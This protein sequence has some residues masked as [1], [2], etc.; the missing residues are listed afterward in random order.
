MSIIDAIFRYNSNEILINLEDISTNENYE[1]LKENLFCS[2]ENCN[3]SL[4]YIP[5]GKYSE[6]LK[7]RVG[8]IHIE[9]CR[10]F[11]I[12][13]LNGRSR[14]TTGTSSSI[15]RDDHVANILRGLYDAYNE[16]D[17]ERESRL[18]QQR[19][20]ARRRRNTRVDDSSTRNEYD[21]V[22]S[23]RPTTSSSGEVLLEGERNP[24]VRRRYSLLDLSN[25]DIGQTEGVIGEL[26]EVENDGRRSLLL[27]SDKNRTIRVCLYL[28]EVFF[29]NSPENLEDNLLVLNEL[30]TSGRTI[31]ISCI[32]EVVFRNESLGMLVLREKDLR[33]NRVPLGSFINS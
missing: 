4:Q 7:K 12:T 33:V 15:L 17:E 8:E 24:P 14:R 20:Y 18:A 3:C 13:N 11:D 29:D 30:L 23:N 16:T 6:Y 2:S 28:E 21:E 32:G 22:S 1:V 5:R 26:V 31:Q 19:A 27:V 10:Y 25:E 9:S